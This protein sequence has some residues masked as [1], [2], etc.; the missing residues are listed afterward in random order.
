[1][2]FTELFDSFFLYNSKD[3]WNFRS[4]GKVDSNNISLG[5]ENIQYH[6]QQILPLFGLEFH[7]NA[8]NI[9]PSTCIVG[10][11]TRR[12]TIKG[13]LSRYFTEANVCKIVLKKVRCAS[14]EIFHELNIGVLAS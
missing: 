9:V 3:E 7:L 2:F 1:V 12:L 8:F 13:R 11:L 14:V 4:Y 6:I 10:T 5:H